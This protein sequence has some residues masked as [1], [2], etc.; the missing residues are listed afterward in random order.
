MGT[1]PKYLLENGA[2]VGD[3]HGYQKVITGDH[4]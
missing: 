2:A 3:T 4:W 1:T